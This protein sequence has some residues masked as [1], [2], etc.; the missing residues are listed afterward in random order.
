M[1]HINADE[2]G[3]QVLILCSAN[4]V[5][6]PMAV[7][8]L[9]RR[10]TE[11]GRQDVRVVS[12]GLEARVGDAPDSEATRVLHDLGVDLSEHRSRAVSREELA[13]SDL[14][15][16]MT[17]AQRGT[18]EHLVPG[19]VTRTFTVLELSRLLEADD[20]LYANIA[21][22]ATG[23]HQARPLTVPRTSTEDVR[24]PHGRPI[25]HYRRTAGQLEAAIDRIAAH[26]APL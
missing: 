1:S 4:I 16:T 26:M 22:L 25:G 5:R 15:L 13:S 8:L 7:G 6:S 2:P 19:L 11:M 17:E 23:A 10:L 21:G 14:V 24:D 20:N 9:R 18:V 12:A 3:Q